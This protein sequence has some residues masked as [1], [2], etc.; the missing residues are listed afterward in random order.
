SPQ[1][2]VLGEVNRAR[3]IVV[4]DE[5]RHDALAIKSVVG[6]HERDEV[7][8]FALA[9]EDDGIELRTQREIELTIEHRTWIDKAADERLVTGESLTHHER[10]RASLGLYL[11]EQSTAHIGEPA[12]FN[13]LDR[14]QSQR[15]DVELRHPIDDV[16][17]AV[18]ARAGVGKVKIGEIVTEPA[19]FGGG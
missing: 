4:A 15:I 2:R 12:H 17:E 5:G 10:V 9:H 7:G 14:I 3:Y 16:L 1:R 18:G 6:V 11:F 13:V 19:R 8:H